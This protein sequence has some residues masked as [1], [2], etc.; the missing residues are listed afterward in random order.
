MSKGRLILINIIGIIIIFALVAGGG[1]YY[2]QSANYVNTDEA[3]VA[4]DMTTIVAPNAGKLTDWGVKEGDQL[5]KDA[6]VGKISGGET[7]MN[8]TA[9]AD[10]TVVKEQA[11]DN[12]MVQPG[13]VLAQTI[14]MNNLYITA[15]IEE[16]D[17]QDIE[18]GDSV[19]ITVDGDPDTIYEGTLENIGYATN[20]MFS[21][22][23]Q[24]NA[25][26]N[27]TKVTQ[28]VSVKVSIKAPSDKVLPGMNAEVKISTK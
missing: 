28:K 26:G 13:Q 2:Y 19:D 4:G 22:M 27:Y 23:P 21:L 25:S 12:Q 11:N 24:Q 3:K 7:S 20:S 9:S 10:G 8:I 16:T 15:N 1:Y 18:E 17:L 5:N 6:N 14:D